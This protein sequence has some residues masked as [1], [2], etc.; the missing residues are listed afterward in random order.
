MPE[1][2]EKTWGRFLT[3][4]VSREKT[5]RLSLARAFIL[6][7][8]AD[9]GSFGRCAV[10]ATIASQRARPRDPATARSKIFNFPPTSTVVRLLLNKLSLPA[11]VTGSIK[12]GYV[13]ASHE[14]SGISSAR[15][16]TCR[17]C[18]L[19][20]QAQGGGSRTET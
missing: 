2:R 1:G 19:R 10:P 17:L 16:L 6:I 4:N 15:N 11:K 8:P 9:V 20:K 7:S 18:S 13:P 3:S 12:R 5:E 14:H